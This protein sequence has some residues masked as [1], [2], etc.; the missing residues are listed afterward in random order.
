MERIMREFFGFGG[1]MREAEG[2]LSWQHLLFVSA[3]M[4]VMIVLAV[5]I[6]RKNKSKSDREKNRVI[7]FSAI[8]IDCLEIV[9]IIIQSVR[10]GDAWLWLYEL[11][12][13]L[14]SIMLIAL[15]LAAF[16]TGRIK[17]AALDFVFIFGVLGAVLGTYGAGNNYGTYPV[18]CF[19][20]VISG[21]THSI[22]GFSALYI[23]ITGM[24]SMKRKNI[25]ITFSV[26]LGFAACAHIANTLLDYNYM[27]LV[28]GDGTPYEVLYML[29]G[30]NAVLY[31]LGVIL[32][33]LLY[34]ISFYGVY[35]GAYTKVKKREKG[36]VSV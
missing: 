34:I 11:P 3:L 9:K 17:E 2:F 31:P 10:E 12:L 5:V 33:F 29:V 26:L 8:L 6:G 4:A 18:L 25:P 19:D 32:L 24:A 20:N 23:G 15:P 30:G 7:V 14:C 13:F 27:F 21:I 22:S 1:Y 16:S 35:Y 36:T 28:R